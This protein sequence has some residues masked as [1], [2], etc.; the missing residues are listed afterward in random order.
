MTDSTEAPTEQGA[1]VTSPAISD[2]ESPR[3]VSDPA[4]PPELEA[5]QSESAL[6]ASIREALRGKR[7][8]KLASVEE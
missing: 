4:S 8:I 1:E 7:V 5:N 2:P 6:W 3:V